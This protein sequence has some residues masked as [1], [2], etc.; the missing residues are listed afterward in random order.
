M[1]KV[2]CCLLALCLSNLMMKSLR[3]HFS[4]GYF[5][6]AECSC[7]RKVL[8]RSSKLCST[9]RM[10]REIRFQAKLRP[11]YNCRTETTSQWLPKAKSTWMTLWREHS[12]AISIASRRSTI[13][14][15]SQENRIWLLRQATRQSSC[16]PWRNRRQ[17][18]KSIQNPKKWTSTSFIYL[19]DIWL[20]WVKGLKQ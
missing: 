12:V 14:W 19:A 3:N 10:S 11:Y 13:H 4:W 9:N 16:G 7:T 8:R 6:V 20:E 17:N 18:P 15:Y 1:L 5:Q 2:S